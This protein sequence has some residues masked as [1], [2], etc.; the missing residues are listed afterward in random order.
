VRVG[1]L[2]IAVAAF[3]GS[4]AGCSSGRDCVGVASV[5]QGEAA[6]QPTARAALHALLATQPRWLDATGWVVAF[7]ASKPDEAV[8]F[9]TAGGDK[10]TVF[11]SP[12][13]GKWYLDSYRG[14]R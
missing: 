14:C 5:D 8:G 10:V 11:R 4:V 6:G 7:T 1:V 3:T 12:R 13:N 2:A 9:V